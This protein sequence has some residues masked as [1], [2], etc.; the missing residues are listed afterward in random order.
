MWNPGRDMAMRLR[1]HKIW[2]NPRTGNYYQSPCNTYF[3][4]SLACLGKHNPTIELQNF[5]ITNEEFLTLTEEN[6][7]YL[8]ELGFLEYILANKEKSESK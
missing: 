8:Q 3:H 2:K 1:S 5:T 7:S 4:M 6:L